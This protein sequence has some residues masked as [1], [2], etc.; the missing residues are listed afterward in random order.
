LPLVPR[1]GDGTGL[2]AVRVGQGA[3]DRLVGLGG[4]IGEWLR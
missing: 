2:V 4:H 1:H 3:G